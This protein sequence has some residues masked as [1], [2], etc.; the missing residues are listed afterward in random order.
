MLQKAYKFFLIVGFF[1]LF[2]V[3]TIFLMIAFIGPPSYTFITLL[4]CMLGYLG[5][6]GFFTYG[7]Q[8][9][10]RKQTIFFLSLHIVCNIILLVV[11]INSFT[12]YFLPPE[13]PC[14][15]KCLE[16][17]AVPIQ[18]KLKIV[19]TFILFAFAPGL[20]FF[21]ACRTLRKCLF[22]EKTP[23]ASEESL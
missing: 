11:F 12:F 15:G 13:V 16:P 3:Y 17:Q 7:E 21:D 9:E 2:V 22:Y 4:A 5:F 20:L 23:D 10:H 8:L 19:A 6:T 1:E 18:K 14:F